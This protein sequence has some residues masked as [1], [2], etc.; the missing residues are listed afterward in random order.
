MKT[1]T[2]A[3]LSAIWFLLGYA[4]WIITIMNTRNKEWLKK[5]E[6]DVDFKKESKFF[7]IMFGVFSFI[8]GIIH[9]I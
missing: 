8:N 3:Y 1:D 5:I 7:H 9:S 2:I 6:E 4:G